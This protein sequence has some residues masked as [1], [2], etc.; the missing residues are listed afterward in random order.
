MLGPISGVSLFFGQLDF[1]RLFT[2][3]RHQYVLD[4]L[5]YA[6]TVGSRDRM[7][8]AQAQRIEIGGGHVWIHTVGFVGD[9]EGGF[10]TIAQMLGNAQIGWHQTGASIDHKQHDVCFFD[11]QQRLTGHACFN[12]IFGAVNAPGIDDNKFITLNLST[13]ILAVSR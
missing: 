13:T 2:D 1:F 7:H 10:L 3:K 8:V 5:R 4:Q 6:T 12:A 9:Q 11:R